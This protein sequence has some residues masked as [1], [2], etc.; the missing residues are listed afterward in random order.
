MSAPSEPTV[1]A[2]PL[3]LVDGDGSAAA[4][5]GRTPD[6][7]EARKRAAVRAEHA[8]RWKLITDAGGGDAFIEAEL[9]NRGLVVDEDPSS[10]TDAQKSA[11]KER[12]KAEAAA[13]RE[14]RRAVW[15]AYRATH[16]VHVGAGVFFRDH[17]PLS[18][19]DEAARLVRAT[20]LELAS[21]DSVAAL[22][23]ALGMTMPELRFLCYHRD[24]DATSHYRIWT[25]PKRDGSRR[26][27]SSPKARLKGAQRW[28][29]RN[30]I[31]KLPVHRA[32][33]GFLRDRSIV[34]NAH[35]H[36]GADV[37]VKVDL[38]DFFPTVTFGRVKGLLRR[39]GLPE[40]VAILCALIATES[41]REVVQF[42]G[43][44]LFVATGPRGLPQGAPTSPAITNALC[45]R[46]D[47]R[48]SGLARVLGFTY[49]RYADDL[50]FSWR[51]ATVEAA[52]EGPPKAPIG[53]LLRGVGAVVRAEGFRINRSKTLVMRA[54]N[55][56]RVTGLVVN[57]AADGVA[58]ARVSRKVLRRLRAAI[59]N[60]EHG[61]P[62]PDN[63][64]TLDQLE[65]MAAFVHMVD[66]AKGRPMLDR[67]AALKR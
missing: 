18:E 38:A 10:L 61:M 45:M 39:A 8:D 43:R 17:I 30:V 1:E 42:R 41:P 65:G 46:L 47:R 22:G 16:V 9:R 20:D 50:T 7:D 19:A 12:K 49:T 4:R 2:T 56:Q 37:I 48:L 51:K 58:K 32:A 6:R 14:L 15:Q 3:V 44:T 26:T 24:V 55:A 67:I 28:L 60:R 33:H 11:F 52:P 36:A 5:P 62:L 54:G 57:P 64:E 13:R 66:P 34:S 40:S 35:A 25:I 29:L 21:L 53:A 31:E 23:K 63:A 59:H 27:I